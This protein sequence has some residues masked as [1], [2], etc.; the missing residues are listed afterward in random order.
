MERVRNYV[1]ARLEDEGFW[2]KNPG[3]SQVAWKLIEN[4]PAI[5]I[6]SG[7]MPSEEISRELHVNH[8]LHMEAYTMVRDIAKK[9]QW[10]PREG[11]TAVQ[12][13]ASAAGKGP[14]F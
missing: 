4:M 2:G 13:L 14:L 8:R 5:A 1:D 3:T 9:M 6:I 11:Q 10:T 12:F 7:D